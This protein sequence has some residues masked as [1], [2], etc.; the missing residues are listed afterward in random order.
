M[1]MISFDKEIA[2]QYQSGG[3]STQL[4]RRRTDRN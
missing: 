3:R 2:Q 1:A 4:D